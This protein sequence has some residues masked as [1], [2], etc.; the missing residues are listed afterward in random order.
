MLEFFHRQ[1]SSQNEDTQILEYAFNYLSSRHPIDEKFLNRESIPRGLYDLLS[2][3]RRYQGLVIARSNYGK[4]LF[5]FSDDK[6]IT[7]FIHYF[8]SNIKPYFPGTIITLFIP[9][10]KEDISLRSIKPDSLLR[11]TGQQ[12][13]YLSIQKLRKDADEYLENYSNQSE[14]KS[15]LYNVEKNG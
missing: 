3:V 4:I 11:F 12:T 6:T 5:D 13:H 8:E 7:E 14:F 15:R 1:H 2:I 10:S 9:E